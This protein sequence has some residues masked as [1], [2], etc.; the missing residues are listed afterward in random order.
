[1]DDFDLFYHRMHLPHIKSQFGDY[2]EIDSYEDMRK[3]FLKGF[4]LFVGMDGLKIAGGLCLIENGTL[5]FRRTGVL[6]GDEGYRRRGAQFALYY[7]II[8]YAWEHGLEKVDTM[9]SDPFL[10]DGVYRT[11][12]EWGASVYPDDEAK[13]TVLY[14]IPRYTTE[15]AYFFEHN[16]VVILGEDGLFGLTGCNEMCKHAMLNK[17]E[18]SKKYYSPGLKG[19]ITLASNG[20]KTQVQ[21]EEARIQG[22]PAIVD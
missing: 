2:A 19:L 22:Q 4:L 1:M 3:Y 12:R 5:F 10:N 6:D 21:F 16:P 18:L 11:K 15:I 14:F 8:R 7:F 9:K 20:K 13:A 17:Q